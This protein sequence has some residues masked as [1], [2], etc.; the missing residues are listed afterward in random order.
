DK[1]DTISAIRKR[2]RQVKPDLLIVD[3]VQLLT[4]QKS[5]D[6]RERDVAT[7]SRELKNMTLDFNI[8]VIQLSQLNDEMKDSR[9]YGDRPM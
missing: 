4:S 6:K 9:P 5:M 3:Y 7:F 8:P 1:I 2:I